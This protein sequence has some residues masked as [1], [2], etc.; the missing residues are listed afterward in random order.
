MKRGITAIIGAAICCFAFWEAARLGLARTFAENAASMN[1]R[2]TADRGVHWLPNDATTHTSRGL[3]LQRT[4]DYGPAVTEFERAAQLRPR[5]YF[6][7][8]LMG[9]TR[10]LNNDQA[11]GVRALRQS[12]ELAPAY[13]KPHWF[14]GNLLLRGRQF[15]EAF[16]ELRF[17]ANSD[18]EL[19]PNVI[20]L[21]WGITR[22]DPQRTVAALQ[23]GTDRARLALA[24]YFAIHKEGEAALEQFGSI[25]NVTEESGDQLLTELLNAKEFTQAYELWTRIHGPGSAS[26]QLLNGDFEE[27]VAIGKRGLGWQIPSELPNVTM[28]VDGSQFQTGGRSLRTDFRGDI[29][30]SKRMLSQLVIVKPNTKYRLT[31]KAMTRD[32]VSTAPPIIAVAGASDDKQQIAKSSP[33]TSAGAWQEFVVDF[34]TAAN[35]QAVLIELTREPC[36]A[37]PCAVFGTL[38]LDSFRL[39]AN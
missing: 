37:Q 27:E 25:R 7:W 26:P 36:A 23:P 5:D 29:D 10:D 4:G 32:L 1:D 33:L 18:A 11:G 30:L 13:A 14:L 21:A 3:V 8:L 28:S 16:R 35:A 22:H 15:E 39:T 19:W 9:V 31:F 20:D 6:P 2:A 34:S 38:W 24:L 17:A 12:I